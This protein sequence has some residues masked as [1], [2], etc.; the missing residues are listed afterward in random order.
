MPASAPACW[1]HQDSLCWGCGLSLPEL[2]TSLCP[3]PRVRRDEG[4]AR[5]EENTRILRSRA[6]PEVGK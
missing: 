1:E 6:V 5:L 2:G 4:F 3:H